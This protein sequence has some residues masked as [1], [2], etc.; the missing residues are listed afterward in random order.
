MKPLFV[1]GCQRSGTTAFAEYLNQHPE[2]L[3]CRERYKYVPTEVT[4]DHLSFDR[5][6]DYRE[7]ETNVPREYHVELL[8]KKDSGR[9]RWIGDK[10]PG[11]FRHYESLREYNPGARFIVLYRPVEEVA[12]SFE[13]RAR[14]EGDL[15]PGHLDFEK[16]VQR[17]NLALEMTRDFI[18]SGLNPNVLIISYH[19][20]FYRNE[21]CI[22]LI[23]RFL[24]VDID[25]SVR[26]A[27]KEMSRQFEG[28]RR[29][30]EPLG[31][32]QAA[33]VEKN[34]DHVAEAWILDRIERQ[35]SEPEILTGGEDTV[36]TP[37]DERREPAAA[38]V[39]ALAE[40]RTPEA[41]QLER[42]V[43]EL[44]SNLADAQRRARQLI[45]Q[46]QQL[47][48][49]TRSLERQMRDMQDSRTWRLL[50]KLGSV[51]ARVVGKR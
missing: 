28:E 30:K 43:E 45:R 35:W 21:V 34:K 12:E 20:F 49:Q 15:W 22:P 40:A 3:V 29:R 1:A 19:D 14:D 37:R 46:N 9:L 2:V 44:K 16:G 38:P 50:K 31:R 27:W 17:W 5:I 26:E 10:N 8:E 25:E 42:R 6:L 11:Y 23:S 48:L 13:A 18:E 7:G 47:T 51:K 4:I 41:Q 39:T 36:L 24:D 33:F 32:K